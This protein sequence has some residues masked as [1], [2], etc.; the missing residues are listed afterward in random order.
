MSLSV[1]QI[2]SGKEAM[3]TVIA[4]VEFLEQ[5]QNDDDTLALA[6]IP[7]IERIERDFDAVRGAERI[8]EMAV[9]LGR[10]NGRHQLR[11]EIAKLIHRC[12]AKVGA[13][14]QAGQK[15]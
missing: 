14:W 7:D 6:L 15:N 8:H 1:E 2:Q 11:A 4:L 10:L 12:R 5:G 3:E 9:E 13:E